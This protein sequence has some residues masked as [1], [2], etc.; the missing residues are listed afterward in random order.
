MSELA[1]VID[2]F[3]EHFASWKGRK[4]LLHGTREYAG[5]I[6][7][8]YDEGFR[9]QGIMTLDPEIGKEFCGKRVYVREDLPDLRP[10]LIILTERVRHEVK[11]YEDLCDLCRELQ[12]PLLNMYGVDET[13]VRRDYEQSFPEDPQ[14]CQDLIEE[15]DVIG[16]EVMNTFFA[17]RGVGNREIGRPNRLV[18]D[19]YE[20][21]RKS[22]KKI[23]FSLRKSFDSQQQLAALEAQGIRAEKDSV[24]VFERKGEDLSFRKAAA[25]GEK[26]LYFGE[27]F[28]NEFLLPRYYGIHMVRLYYSVTASLDTIIQNYRQEKDTQERLQFADACRLIDSCEVISFDVFDTL[29]QRCVLQPQ[30]VIGWLAEEVQEKLG[31]S[32]ERFRQARIRA[33]RSGEHPSLPEIYARTAA[34][35]DRDPSALADLPEKELACEKR[36]LQPRERIAELLEYAK[37]KKK[38]VILTSDMYL[39]A[40]EIAELLETCGI[41]GYEKIFVSVDCRCSKSQGLFEIV[42]KE[43]P[44]KKILHIGDDPEADIAAARKAGCEAL[45]LRSALQRAVDCGYGDV[46]AK[47]WD[48]R[49]RSLLGLCLSEAFADPFEEDG[50]RF[51]DDR[52]RLLRFAAMACTPLITGFLCELPGTA[53]A[54][55][56]VLFAARDGWLLKELYDRLRLHADCPPGSYLYTSRRASFQACMDDPETISE[57]YRGKEQALP[58]YLRNVYGIAEPRPLSDPQISRE[59]YIL[60]HWPEI[61]ER[62]KRCRANTLR[63]MEK[64]GISAEKE[65]IFIDFVSVGTT[66][67]FL[68]KSS[69]FSLKGYF[70]ARPYYGDAFENI[71]YYLSSE[72]RFFTAHYMEMEYIM[73]SP[74]PSLTGFTEDGLPLFAEEVRHAS[75]LERIAVVQEEVRK[76]VTVFLERFYRPG[77]EIDPALAAAMYSAEGIHGILKERGFDD[78]TGQTI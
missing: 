72:E 51:L 28:V 43:Y 47:E 73:T 19:L 31:V 33:E 13:E 66:L 12:I 2:R 37:K 54:K 63:Y 56:G 32:A 53:A 27:G 44:G 50:I 16:F 57:T 8:E 10:D 70:F 24:F 55:D 76:L 7:K 29:L 49:E 36:F 4:I 69:G 67:H 22:G 78:W 11:A 26:V 15:C 18:W 48:L 20:K 46:L 77:T 58:A 68:R 71:D 38:T 30:D 34:F 42:K 6:V 40:E 65:Y 9:F 3:P 17:M 1:Y 52:R 75:D 45:H 5:E 35:L 25:L 64:E 41:Q 59:D 21:A 62:A 60:Q 14:T 74:E 23:F 39:K 61:T